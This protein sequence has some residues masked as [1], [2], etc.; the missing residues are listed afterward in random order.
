M[1]SVADWPQAEIGYTWNV[2]ACDSLLVAD[3]PQAEIGY[4]LTNR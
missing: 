1:L 3:W 4:T 2:N